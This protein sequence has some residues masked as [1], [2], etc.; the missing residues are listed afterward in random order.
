MD[1]GSSRSRCQQGQRL[2]RT[3]SLRCR[4]PLSHHV[5][6]RRQRPCPLH[7]RLL[8]ES[9]QV[10]APDW[11]SHMC[12]LSCFSRVQLHDAMDHGLPGSSVHGILQARILGWVVISSSRGSS[13]PMYRTH[14]SHVSRI[15]GRFFTAESSRKPLMTSF[16]LNYLL[17]IPLLNIHS[18]I[19]GKSLD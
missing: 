14:I 7:P 18:Q 17:K 12:M 11:W 6:I 9:Y 10:R 8:S 3:F 19:S 5:L 2:V 15:A 13:Q 1:T 16:N 4:W